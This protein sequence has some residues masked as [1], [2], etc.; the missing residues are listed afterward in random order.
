MDHV[1][2]SLDQWKR[3]WKDRI[4]DEMKKPDYEGKQ[5]EI[6]TLQKDVA[7]IEKAMHEIHKRF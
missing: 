3:I 6:R 7:A 4:E 5:L 1:W 2:N